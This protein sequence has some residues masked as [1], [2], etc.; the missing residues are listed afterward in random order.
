M[1]TVDLL[2]F[3]TLAPIAALVAGYLGRKAQLYYWKKKPRIK[4]Y[5]RH[6]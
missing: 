4:F 1:G 3:I 5:V 6:W 2:E